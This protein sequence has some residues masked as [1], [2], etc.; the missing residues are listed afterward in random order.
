MTSNLKLHI[1]N[2]ILVRRQ[3]PPVSAKNCYTDGNTTMFD[4][5]LLYTVRAWSIC[6][7]WNRFQFRFHWNRLLQK[8]NWNRIC[9]SGETIPD[10]GFAV[11]TEKKMADSEKSETYAC[12]VEFNLAFL[13]ILW[14]VQAIFSVISEK[15]GSFIRWK[16][17]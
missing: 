8:W 6:R 1:Y 13:T 16:Q 9:E 11:E 7:N 4:S 15:R 12:F 17:V 3:I 14:L 2:L 10:H 5:S